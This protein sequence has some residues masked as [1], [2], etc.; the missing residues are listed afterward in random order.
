MSD[1]LLAATTGREIGSRPSRRLR[2]DGRVPGVVYGLGSDPVTISVD[3]ADLRA[4]LNTEAGTNA[5]ITLDVEGATQLSIITDMQRHPVRRDVLH[6]DF[7]RLDPDAELIVEVP[8]VLTGEAKQVTQASGMVDQIM[9]HI[10][11]SAR[12]GDIP[13]EI[14]A[15]V[16]ELEV[17]VSLRVSD[18]D[19]PEGVTTAGDPDATFAVGVIT[20]STRE[21]MRAERLAEEEIELAELELAEGEEAGEAEE[22]AAAGDGGGG[23]GGDSDES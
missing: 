20:R 22:G 23:G 5:L 9:H 17:G 7:L 2:R 21:F 12:P 8:L 1:L 18:I 15:D 6:V 13:S 10:P 14:Q 4:A 11:L 19:L 16:S 3:R